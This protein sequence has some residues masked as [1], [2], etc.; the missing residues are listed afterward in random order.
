MSWVAL[1]IKELR[2]TGT[3]FLFNLLF[4]LMVAILF[5]ILIERY[6][7]FFIT[8]TIP[9]V[10]VHLFYM[11][12]A[13]LDS[14]RQEW[15]QKTSVF[16]LNIPK[17]GWQ[18]LTAK[19]LA[20]S[21]QLFVSLTIT[22]WIIHFLL[23]R[24]I[25]YFADP[26]MPNFLIEQ[27]QSFWWILFVVIFIASLQSGM[28]ATFIYMVAKSLRKWGWLLGVGIVAVGSWIWFKFQETALYQGLTE[29]GVILKE[30]VLLEKMLF[31]FNSLNE[32]PTMNME[33]GNNA[34]LYMGT[35]VMDI[36]LVVIVLFI[37]AW[38]LDHKVEA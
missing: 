7:P 30:E 19:F 31:H 12:F 15:K 3:K 23:K 5:F 17:S 18:L 10:I 24:S 34:V 25:N 9:L 32:D 6:S 4:L 14:L 21:T 1:Y 38:L 20:A 8:L 35:A 28:V 33:L 37:S 11:F 29:W 2:L 22:F 16:W 36:L 13:M 26:T 27:F